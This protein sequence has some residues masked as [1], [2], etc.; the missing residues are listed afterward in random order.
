MNSFLK[1]NWPLLLLL[2]LA[3]LTR[4]WHLGYP[5][6]VVFDEVN[7]GKYVS[8]YFTQEYYFEIHPPLSKLMIAGTAKLFG[9]QPGSDFDHIGEAL[10]AKSIVALRFL[11]ALFGVLFVAIVYWM[12]LALNFSRPAAF[13]GGFLALFD[14]ALLVESKFIL[15]DIFLLSFGF[16]ALCCYLRSE[17]TSGKKRFISYGLASVFAGLAAGVKFTGVSFF[18]LI[19]LFVFIKFLHD[20]RFKKFLL[21][22]ALFCA[23]AVLTY[24]LPFPLHFALLPKSGPGDAYMSAAFSDTAEPLSFW[25]KFRELNVAMYNYNAG[26][27]ADH[28]DGSRWYEWPFDRK[29]VY[30][31]TKSD[32]GATAKIYFI[33][34]PFIWWLTS[35]AV[36]LSLVLL[37]F[38]TLRRR[39]GPEIYFLLAGYFANLLPFILVTRVAFL[40]HYLSSLIFAAL[41][42]VLLLDRLIMP[43]QKH[44]LGARSFAVFYASLLI[45]VLVT[46][47]LIAPLSYGL[48]ISPYFQTYYD[49]FINAFHLHA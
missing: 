44:R 2:F 26:I 37:V 6:E 46:F 23:I 35:A 3:V 30:Y 28:P 49:A 1:K 43:A 47:L 20:L 48:P 25:G 14:N 31:W 19:L 17:K 27:T 9:F 42:T 10:D 41:I 13:L 11:P 15:F 5:A 12:G 40:Y 8:A 39:L 24:I 7:F 34:N 45:V 29:P 33:G 22:A 38:A 32:E 16:S 36:A 21:K 4:F 18:G